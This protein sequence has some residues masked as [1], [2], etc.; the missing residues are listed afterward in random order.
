MLGN[1]PFAMRLS[2]LVSAFLTCVA[3]KVVA[4]SKAQGCHSRNQR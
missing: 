3:D 1:S 2:T 4:A